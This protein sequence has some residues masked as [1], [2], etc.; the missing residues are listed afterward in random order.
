MDLNS[1]LTTIRTRLRIFLACIAVTTVVAAVGSV[2]LPPTYE[3]STQMTAGQALGGG[4]SND[5]NALQAA[6][7]IASTYA[8]AATTQGLAQE[9]I[10]QLGLNTTPT[11]LL[12]QISVSVDTQAPVITIKVDSPNPNSAASIANAVAQRLLARAAAIQGQD[13][14]ILK[15][16]QD[17][18]TTV[19]SQLTADT[20]SIGALQAKP[21]PLSATDQATLVSLQ[22]AV[23]AYQGDL[24]QLLATQAT[25]STSVMAV[26]DPAHVPADPSS[27][28]LL[29]NIILAL[30]LGSALGLGLAVIA[31]SLDDSFKTRDELQAAT[32]LP[33]LGVVGRMPEAARQSGIY[34]LIMLLFPRSGAAEAF[35]S[36][37]TNVEFS[38]VD[39]GLHSILVTSPSVGEGKST[40]AANL[41][42]AFAQGGRRTVLVDA[43]LRRPS[44][45]E[46]FGLSNTYGLTTLVRSEV[47]ELAQVLRQVDEPNLRVLTSGPLPP[48]PAELMGSNRMRAIVE[49]L[50]AQADLVIF[51]SPPTA[52]V[53]D[54]VVL[55]TVVDAV[56]VV[57][58]GGTTRRGAFT[59]S[60]EAIERV[61]GHLI[62][63][64]LN[65]KRGSDRDE[66]Y[67]AYA[68]TAGGSEPV[69]SEAA[70]PA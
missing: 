36:L 67:E 9:V 15:A 43:D 45:H 8:A 46:M 11:K 10:D 2:I 50:E 3:A 13:A 6:Q 56:M 64:V 23:V 52:A 4:N 16:I 17:Q 35:R 47:I 63:A 25:T 38:D 20:A 40:V 62:G 30:V 66:G 14:G 19:Q 55:A 42:L 33:V 65:Q 21:Q 39:A 59:R 12:K 53:T 32:D 60:N 7:T 27:P 49:A 61:G 29:L 31:S 22:Q 57:V 68:Q 34:A 58:A 18:V 28:V 5:I 54:A 1:V 24:T 41:A 44:L 51:D 26:L 37:R 70:R 69:P 48:N